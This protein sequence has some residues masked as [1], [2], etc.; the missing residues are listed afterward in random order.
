MNSTTTTNTATT[1][2]ISATSHITSTSNIEY[3]IINT[4]ELKSYQFIHIYSSS[5]HV[6]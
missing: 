1:A 4:V 3:D 5:I 6:S 2:T